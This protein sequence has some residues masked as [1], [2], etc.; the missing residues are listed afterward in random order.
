M[1]EKQGDNRLP[2]DM[3]SRHHARTQVIVKGELIVKHLPSHLAQSLF[4]KAG[5]HPIIMRYSSGPGDP[6]LYDR[7][8]QPRGLGTKSS[9]FAVKYLMPE[10]TLIP[11]TLKFTVLQPA[12]VNTTKEIIDLRM[13]Y[14]GDKAEL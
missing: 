8:S 10:R 7:I 5:K 6:Y 12:D 13:K 14:S 4:S 1:R 2:V 9:M 11:R 3:S